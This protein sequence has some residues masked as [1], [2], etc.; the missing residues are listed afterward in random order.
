M[1]EREGP[2]PEGGDGPNLILVGL[3]GTETSMRAGAYAAGLARRQGARLVALYVA[4]TSGMASLAPGGAAAV[5]AHDSIAD[6]LR[7]QLGERAPDLGISATFEMRHGDPFT[8]FSR[9]ADTLRA[10]AVVVG[11]SMH[12]GHRLVGSLG[13][14]LVRA[15]KWPVTV[16]P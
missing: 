12:A 3:D 6:D 16:V 10:D 5:A 9:V 2:W 15:G 8:E 14:K 1:A 4:P 13:V 11:A 7:R